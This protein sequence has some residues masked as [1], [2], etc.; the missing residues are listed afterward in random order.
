MKVAI[1]Q[2]NPTIADFDGNRAKILS[3]YRD[4]CDRGVE[5]VVF[6]ELCLCGYP[7]LDFLDRPGFLEKCKLHLERLAGAIGR[8]PA[9]V[10][11]AL[12]NPRPEGRQA[13]NAAAV[14]ADGRVT[15]TVFKSRL[16]TYDV[17]DEDRYF[18][19]APENGVVDVNGLRLGVTICEDIWPGPDRRPRYHRDPVAQ[20]AEQGPEL[21]VN[22]SASPFEVGKSG[23]RYRLL[24]DVARRLK[25]P[26]VLVN[27]VGGND[28]LLFDGRSIAV[29]AEGA[30]VARAAAFSEDLL[31]V[32]F[33]ASTNRI[34]PEPESEQ[35]DVCRALVM[36]IADYARKCG[37]SR[38]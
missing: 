37:L 4:A 9:V 21:A 23:L 26:A 15:A 24:A 14:L 13:V 8:V 31:V 3:A 7:P 25:V 33:D 34:E 35:A 2:L 20:L 19:P 36:G 18:E 17:F 16:P 38:A 11:C 6:S 29:D 32:D 12:P 30:L 1:A 28:Q 10:G 5:L 22:L 27:Q